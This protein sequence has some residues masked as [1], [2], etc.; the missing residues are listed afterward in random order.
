MV[1]LVVFMFWGVFFVYIK[2]KIE[3][4]RLEEKKRI[5]ELSELF[6]RIF[7]EIIDWNK[8]LLVRSFSRIILKL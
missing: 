1:L 7:K 5:V 3:L 6:F 2:D 8:K 4:I